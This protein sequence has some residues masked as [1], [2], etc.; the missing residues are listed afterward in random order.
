MTVCDCFDLFTQI[1]KELIDSFHDNNSKAS[2][3]SLRNEMVDKYRSEITLCSELDKTMTQK[4]IEKLMKRAER[5]KSFKKFKLLTDSIM[6]LSIQEYED[7]FW[8]EQSSKEMEE[9]MQKA[10]EIRE[11]LDSMGMR[12]EGQLDS[13]AKLEQSQSYLSDSISMLKKENEILLEEMNEYIEEIDV[14]L[15]SM[16][17]LEDMMEEI[18]DMEEYEEWPEEEGDKSACDCLKEAMNS[19]EIL[20]KA[21]AGCEWMDNLDDNQLMEE[22]KDCPEMAAMFE[23]VM[24]DME[25][26]DAIAPEM[27]DMMEEAFEEE[28]EPEDKSI[29]ECLKMSIANPDLKEPPKGSGCEWVM[30]ISNEEGEKL[31]EQAMVDCPEMFNHQDSKEKETLEEEDEYIDYILSLEEELEALNEQRRED[32]LHIREMEMDISEIEYELKSYDTIPNFDKELCRCYIDEGYMEPETPCDYPEMSE[33][34]WEKFG[35]D[36]D[37]FDFLLQEISWMNDYLDED[38]HSLDL[39]DMERNELEIE[40]QMEKEIAELLEAEHNPEGDYDFNPDLA[41]K[42]QEIFSALES[43]DFDLF[44][45]LVK[46]DTVDFFYWRISSADFN[47]KNLEGMSI[48]IEGGNGPITVNALEYVEMF[49]DFDMH[50]L[51]QDKGRGK[52]SGYDGSCALRPGVAFCI[53]TSDCGDSE[54]DCYELMVF[55]DNYCLSYLLEEYGSIEELIP[56]P[57]L[58]RD[59]LSHCSTQSEI[60][61]AFDE[62]NGFKFIGVYDWYWTP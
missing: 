19:E 24:P 39:L 22:L 51:E 33:D 42:A 8:K 46:V 54:N 25:D 62:S 4:E 18:P 41:F 1:Q 43:E 35:R 49:K 23:M 38:L 47:R 11:E 13:I 7:E 37:R 57:Y 61:M 59:A 52:G 60:W 32:I 26:M 28:G 17:D 56:Y 29:C 10:I 3:E 15:E 21:P 16:H 36:C 50:L 9:E 5:C 6:H 34:E 45:D 58:M 48:E 53:N 14:L 44:L 30:E 31:I 55:K 12:L 20:D 27:E 2:I 40:I